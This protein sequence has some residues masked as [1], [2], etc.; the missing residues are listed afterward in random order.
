MSQNQ[1]AIGIDI[2]GTKTGVAV[3]DR[4]GVI[5]ARVAM[6]TRSQRGFATCLAELLDSIRRVSKEA[7]CSADDL[8][9]VGIGCAGPVNPMRGTIHNPYTLPGWDDADIVTALR[10]A[11][12]VP[13][14]L[15]ND[16]DAAAVG[17]FWFGAGRAATPLAMVTLG[18]GIG[19][20][21]L[22]NGAIFR[23]LNGEHP[24]LGHIP[25]Q[26]D[27]PECYCGTRGC[28]ES[29]A[30]GTAIAAAGLPF[31]FADSRAVF[32]GAAN[33][34]NAAAI[35]QRAV[36]AT[37][38]AAWTILHACAPQRII[39]GGGIGEEHFELFAHAMREQIAPATQV[40]ARRVDILKA[41][42]GND[43]GVIGAACLAFH[44]QHRLH[45]PTEIPA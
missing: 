6:P 28:W 41:E 39:I 4:S 21:M 2:G 14:L 37:R 42:L 29:L 44:A 13:V 17:E 19:G 12:G 40:S 35:V 24:E 20:A 1:Q 25:V 32:V 30:S 34:P 18:T 11:L 33:D 3:V 43:A 36:Q 8:C 31:A 22:I 45:N 16:A 15:E 10:E 7:S 9:G 5:R 23:G 26:A 38:T 27:G